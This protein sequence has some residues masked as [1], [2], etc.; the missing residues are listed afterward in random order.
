MRISALVILAI[1]LLSLLGCKEHKMHLPETLTGLDEVH[2]SIKSPDDK[3][4]EYEALCNW[5]RAL[6]SE[7][8]EKHGIQIFKP[9]TDFKL[10]KRFLEYET[11][12]TPVFEGT[13]AHHFL[14]RAS[15][16]LSER[17]SIER[18]TQSLEMLTVTW[19]RNYAAWFTEES[20]LV[21]YIRVSTDNMLIE[22]ENQ[23]IEDN[24]DQLAGFIKRPY[25]VWD[26]DS[27]Q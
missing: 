6:F 19:D 16:R 26:K 20:D 8:L 25:K 1:A 11:R 13:P 21:S 23:L 17:A 10:P 2:L 9:K 22:F 15:L 4:D 24:P 27:E 7:S 5:Q 12:I 18:P 14:V 3:N